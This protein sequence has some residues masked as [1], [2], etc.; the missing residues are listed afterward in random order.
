M[1]VTQSHFKSKKLKFFSATCPDTFCQNASA[2]NFE[3]QMKLIT[4]T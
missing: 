4:D 2:I 3:L 1:K